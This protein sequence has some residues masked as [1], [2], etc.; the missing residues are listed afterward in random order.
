[1]AKRKVKIC[2]LKYDLVYEFPGK[3]DNGKLLWGSADYSKTR[4]RL[5]PDRRISTERK[6]E[7]FIHECLH[8]LLFESCSLQYIKKD[9][10]EAFIE[11]V[12]PHVAVF[13]RDN[14]KLIKKMGRF[15]A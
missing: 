11:G 10:T 5:S 14:I 13:I 12:A 9:K 4:L 6:F 7:I 15:N 3:D 1:M 2:G 8:A